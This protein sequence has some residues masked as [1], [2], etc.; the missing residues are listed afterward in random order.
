MRCPP[1]LVVL[2]AGVGTWL[3]P[4]V[5][6]ARPQYPNVFKE[7]YTKI[8][9]SQVQCNVCHSQLKEKSLL[10]PYGTDLKESLQVRNV[11]DTELILKALR[12][13]EEKFAPTGQTWGSYLLNGELPPTGK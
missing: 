4:A 7:T 6:E 5:A 3:G 8:P 10:T 13:T 9:R 12:E 1:S 11:K 2:F